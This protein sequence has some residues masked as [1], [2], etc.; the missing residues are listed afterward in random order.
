MVRKQYRLVWNEKI[1][2]K[3]EAVHSSAVELTDNLISFSLSLKKRFVWK[4]SFTY[5]FHQVYQFVII[6]MNAIA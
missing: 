5:Y 3:N 2:K 6:F 4:Y 1:E